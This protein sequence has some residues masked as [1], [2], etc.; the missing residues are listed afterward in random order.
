ML[1]KDPEMIS[2]LKIRVDSLEIRSAWDP[3]QCSLEMF[4]KI[5]KITIFI[6]EINGFYVKLS[7]DYHLEL[8]GLP[9][10]NIA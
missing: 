7:M 1:F 9:K 4:S 10:W 5:L 8:T 2:T 6:Y 3:F